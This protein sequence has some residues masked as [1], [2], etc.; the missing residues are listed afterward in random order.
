MPGVQSGLLSC[1]VRA[2]PAEIPYFA[3]LDSCS[4]LHDML[5]THVRYCTPYIVPYLWL[6][7]DTPVR[8]VPK[9]EATVLVGLYKHRARAHRF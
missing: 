5:C 3:C 9:L 2:E 7:W 6:E 1:F 4:Q 8:R